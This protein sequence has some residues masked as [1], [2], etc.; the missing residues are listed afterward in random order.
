VREIGESKKEK[1]KKTKRERR[2][3]ERKKWEEQ[4]TRHIYK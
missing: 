4:N 3:E 2:G 1:G